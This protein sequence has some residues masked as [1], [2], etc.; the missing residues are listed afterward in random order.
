MKKK[1][2]LRVI[3]CLLI[4]VLIFYGDSGMIAKAADIV[5][6]VVSETMEDIELVPGTT[7]H[8]K[9]PVRTASS[10]YSLTNLTAKVSVLGGDSSSSFFKVKNISFNRPNVV[11][12]QNVI[13]FY[14]T[15]YIEFDII[16]KE[17][18]TFG[19]YNI[20]IT[21]NNMNGQFT[22]TPLSIPCNI[23]SE[24]Q[25]AEITVT[26]F[27]Y[28]K[29]TAIIGNDIDLSLMVKNEGEIKAY[30]TYVSVD[31][32]AAQGLKPNYTVTKMKL[33]DMVSGDSQSVKLPISI[34]KDAKA[35][36]KKLIVNFSYK[37][38]S[39]VSHTNS[40]E[41]YVD[42]ISN[43]EA[44]KLGF[45]NVECQ[46]ELLVGTDF[47]IVATL[48]NTGDSKAENIKVKVTEGIAANSIMPDYSLGY[49]SVGSLKKNDSGQVEIPLKISKDA[50]KGTTAV[51]IEATYEDASGVS[52]TEKT[53]VYPVIKVN[54]ETKKEEGAP[55]IIINNVSQSPA[56]PNAGEQLSLSFELENRSKI[57]ATE[58]KIATTGLSG[59]SFSPIT[60]DPYIYLDELKAGDTKYITMVFDVSKSIAE[61]YNTIPLTYSYKYGENNTEE[62]KSATLNVLNVVN[63]VNDL[64]KSVPK[65]II[66]N[67]TTDVEAIKAGQTFKFTYDIKN[68]HSTVAAKNIKVTI[69]QA[70]NVFSVPDGSNSSYIEQ[71]KPG[72]TEVCSV[73]LK[74]KADATT[75]AYPLTI[76]MSYEYDGATV[77][78]VTGKL[79][80]EVTESINLQAVENCR[81]ELLNTYMDYY[82]TPTVGEPTILYFDFYNMGRSPLCNVYATISGDFVKTDGEKT[83]IGNVNSGDCQNVEVDVT[84]LVE[85]D[86]KGIITITFEDSNGE[87]MTMTQEF[88]SYV[89]GAYNYDSM[90]G[91][92]YIDTMAPVA[93]AKKP[94]LPLWAFIGAQVVIFMVVTLISRAVVIKRYKKKLEKAE[95][96]N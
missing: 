73:D 68:T 8:V 9:V 2:L 50:V 22:T 59:D 34:F 70:E 84:P 1:S 4:A 95:Q 94:I 55:N 62:S 86:A 67:Y 40:T 30:S 71:I 88:S 65:L 45:T 6:L 46:G 80:E 48:K 58:L 72:E 57:D 5:D 27:S 63:D 64:S 19:Q 78:P 44:P 81:P 77:S 47:K 90:G 13:T 60:Q 89:Q 28:P 16:T 43:E 49:V 37:D 83:M 76:T 56:K 7:T 29:E 14:S 96:E 10:D 18:A 79:G 25:P 53:I 15:T 17:T 91:M 23:N 33:G 24:L 92:D 41:L 75:K 12:S 21:C 32:T 61:G 74:V 35:E 93:T 26:N 52:Y 87:E 66:S 36:T 39:G 54:E 11:D 51:T 31:Y 20:S 3:S 82:S 69:T 42:V 38:A 85:G